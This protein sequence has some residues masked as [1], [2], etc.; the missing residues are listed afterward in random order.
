MLISV[1][2]Y[3]ILKSNA[4]TNIESSDEELTLEIQQILN[5]STKIS[6]EEEEDAR[7]TTPKYNRSIRG[8]L[9][10]AEKGKHRK[11]KFK[12]IWVTKPEFK[13]CHSS[14]RQSQLYQFQTFLDLQDHKILHPSAT[15]WLSLSSVVNRIIEQ[16]DALRL[17]LNEKWLSEKLASTRIICEQLNDPF[18][19]AFY[20]LME[21]VLPKFTLL[22]KY[23]QSEKVILDKLHE[24]IMVAYKDLLLCFMESSYIMHTPPE[25]INI[26]DRKY[27]LQSK[28]IYLGVKVI[29]F[30]SRPEITKRPDL[31]F[32][33]YER[34][35][36][37]LIEGCIQ[38]KKKGGIV[39]PNLEDQIQVL[40][41]QW[42]LLVIYDFPKYITEVEETDHFWSSLL[43]FKDDSDTTVFSNLAKFAHS[44]LSLPHSNADCE[45]IFSKINRTKTKGRNKLIQKTVY[46]ILMTSEGI[47]YGQYDSF[48][49]AQK[50][51]DI[52]K[53]K[54]DLSSMEEDLF[55]KKKIRRQIKVCSSLQS[56]SESSPSRDISDN[57]NLKSSRQDI[58]YG[59]R[60][61]GWSPLKVL[62]KDII[63]P[64][65]TSLATSNDDIATSSKKVA[66]VFNVTPSKTPKMLISGVKRSL[67]EDI[68]YNHTNPIQHKS[69]SSFTISTPKSS[70]L[71]DDK[72][73]KSV[74][75]QLLTLK[76]EMC[77]INEKLNMI[78]KLVEDDK[79][80]V[81]A[82][83]GYLEFSQFDNDF[84]INS[85]EE[86]INVETK[87]SEDKTYRANLVKR[88]SSVGGK[89]IPIMVKRIM[90]LVFNPKLLTTFPYNGRGNKKR[91]FV[92][93][94]VNKIIFESIFKIKK[95]ATSDNST[96][97]IEQVL[98]YVLIQT[99]FKLKKQEGQT[100]AEKTSIA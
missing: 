72:F 99:P 39:D 28:D 48:S 4:K 97:E 49:N 67:F 86:L 1:F 34:C 14:K 75:H 32:D 33:F 55:K 8:E 37:F 18:T 63:V 100:T 15:R 83:T 2:S 95:F 94:L 23:F 89:T 5:N 13:N 92:G 25:E 79:R 56:D 54:S 78:V 77:T 52:A 46:S 12:K 81:S 69:D 68:S 21:W 9:K 98:K 90:S 60:P 62:K 7:C 26:T 88:L 44:V 84:P 35:S 27:Y 30:I 70:L 53:V 10:R 57:K 29:N 82:D 22:N 64:D 91:S 58:G 17:F 51:C 45:R 16:W 6:D 87:I 36:N 31:L 11:Q 40:D 3:L 66:H 24:R 19:K 59:R 20:L 65:K 42:R 80:S 74:L 41:D 73:K 96:N 50:K 71:D 61:D 43:L 76:F 38:I 85:Y 47:Q 93:L